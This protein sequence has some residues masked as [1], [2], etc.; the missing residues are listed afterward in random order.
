MC[1]SLHGCRCRLDLC[2]SVVMSVS[3]QGCHCRLALYVNFIMC[4]L[5]LCK[6]QDDDRNL[7]ACDDYGHEQIKTVLTMQV[8]SFHSVSLTDS[9]CN[10]S[11]RLCSVLSQL[12][13][14]SSLPGLFVARNVLVL[15]TGLS[16]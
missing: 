7:C 16:D 1:V 8:S 5:I 6:E 12:G 15:Y 9:F 3:V 4:V 2:V 11:L 14:M 10:N 13:G